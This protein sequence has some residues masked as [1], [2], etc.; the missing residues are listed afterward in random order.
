MM[1][2]QPT[3]TMGGRI[4][5]A[6]RA[7]QLKQEALAARLGVGRSVISN[8]ENGINQPPVDKIVPLCKALGVSLSYLFNYHNGSD[9][10]PLA[11]EYTEML[12]GLDADGHRVVDAVLR[13]EFERCNR[14]IPARS[15]G[16]SRPFR[17]IPFIPLAASAGTGVT[18]DDYPAEEIEV[19]LTANSKR[20]DFAVRVSGNSMEPEFHDGELLLVQKTDTV[21][22]GE[23]GLF[24]LNGEGYFKRLGQGKL[25]S[26]N[27]DYPPIPLHPTD[28]IH[29]FGRVLGTVN[30]A[31]R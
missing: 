16:V 4:R 12:L 23:L 21:Q 6:R 27:A 14:R 15:S 26:L 2:T 17:V 9:E 5:Q 28:H 30:S 19:E 11:A 20:A 8:W 7:Q 3:F 1:Q 25:I 10:T 24:A 31:T 13:L 29:V 18:L 22:P